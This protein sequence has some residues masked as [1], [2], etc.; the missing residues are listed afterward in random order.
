MLLVYHNILQ[1]TLSFFSLLICWPCTDSVVIKSIEDESW[2]LKDEQ[3][4]L[5]E[6]LSEI[7]LDN[8][9]KV[10]SA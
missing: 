6:A 2:V 3:L 8:S 1:I 7:T 9:A 10:L 4:Y 5:V